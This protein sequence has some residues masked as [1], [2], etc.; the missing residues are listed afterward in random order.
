[1]KIRYLYISQQIRPQS[2]QYV[3]QSNLKIVF[4]KFSLP[5]VHN[6]SIYEVS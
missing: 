3:L 4:D 6:D 2:K 1:M 5:S